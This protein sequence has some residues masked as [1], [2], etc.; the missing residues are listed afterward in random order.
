MVKRTSK[1]LGLTVVLVLAAVLVLRAS[2]I[3]FIAITALDQQGLGPA[4][5]T[6]SQ[7]NLSGLELEAV[8]LSS[9]QITAEKASV[10]YTWSSLREGRI[11]HLKLSGL[12]VSGIW[13]DEG[14]NLG[15]LSIPQ[16]VD[17]EDETGKDQSRTDGLPFRSLVIEN[18]ALHMRHPQ[19]QINLSLNAN[20]QNT[21]EI[22]ETAISAELAGPDLAGTIDISGSL[23][24]QDILT[25]SLFGGIKL[26]AES[27]AIPG[28]KNA[29]SADIDLNA[30]IQDKAVTVMAE[31]DMRFSAPWPS[32]FFGEDNPAKEQTVEV[33]ISKGTAFEPLFRIQPIDSGYRADV[34]IIL[35]GETPLGRVGVTSLAWAT[36]GPDGL[37]QDFSFETFDVALSDLPTPYGIVSA[38]IEASGLTGP[39]AIAGGPVNITLGVK[40]AVYGDL[41]S[42]NLTADIASDFRLDGLSLAFQFERLSAALEDLKYGTQLDAQETIE[43][44]LAAEGDATQ[45]TNLVFG[46]DGS[47]TITFD[48]ALAVT[49]KNMAVLLNNSPL[50]INASMP[51][52][53]VKGYWTTSDQS[54]DL[55]IGIADGVIDT[56]SLSATALNIVLTGDLKD[57]SGTY[58]TTLESS[59]DT[60][61]PTP[62]LR[63]NGDL[64]KINNIYNIQGFARLPSRS[65]VGR[66]S[67]KYDLDAGNGSATASTGPLL[68]GGDN[69]GPSDLR[70]LGLPFIPTAGEVAVDVDVS[71]SGGELGQQQAHI[72]VREVDVEGND[73]AL[74][75][76]NT[77]V[78]FDS[79]VPPRTDG[80]Q[81]VAIGLLQVGVPITDFLGTF[82]LNS[83]DTLE[84]DKVSMTFAEG[85]VIGGPLSLRLDQEETLAE[86]SVNNV[87]LPALASM[88]ELQGLEATGTLAGRIPISIKGSDILI[89]SG[90]LKTSG[91]GVVKYRTSSSADTIAADQGGL[92]LALQALQDFR[93]DSIEVTVSGSVQKELEA[94]LAIKG[95]NPDLYDGYP[96]DFNLNLSGELANIIRGSMA[97]Y[98]VPE[99]IKRQLM[100]FPPSP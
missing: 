76:L 43:L 73:F 42:R 33:V 15:G 3:E 28:S 55:Q 40:D 82:A 19:G 87:S 6:V 56:E 47:A 62:L 57:M 52:V 99:T 96:I 12:D 20:M 41:S 36:F 10:T 27:F 45:T 29:F 22:L 7:A 14:L 68:F 13:S 81:T 4:R 32:Q 97:G 21:N 26:S 65:L 84:V 49:S 8:S 77:A 58:L 78:A 23:I 48:T 39:I 86:L 70:P 2:L 98:R 64:S 91:P 67:L 46:A 90:T 66:Y 95:R 53:S 11:E 17:Q 88:T 31:K 38:S 51:E 72:Y 5:L 37:P 83:S 34:D 59:K 89:E 50:L 60:S 1:F 9:G 18:A 24:P 25:S 94:S 85:E 79:L 54:G 44:N 80:P 30:S 75:R 93:Y 100:A 92:S 16:Q 63:L 69:L 35:R 61:K 71:F 74:R